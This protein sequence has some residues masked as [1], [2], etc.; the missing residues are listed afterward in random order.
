MSAVGS[1]VGSDVGAD[2]VTAVGADVGD[3]LGPAVG[4]CVGTDVGDA[5]GPDVGDAVGTALGRC[6]G[7]AVGADVGAAV[8]RD[9]GD[10][11]GP[12]ARHVAPS[13]LSVATLALTRVIPD[14]CPGSP[15][16]LVPLSARL[17]RK[18]T[19]ARPETSPESSRGWLE[20]G[21]SGGARPARMHP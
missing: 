13:P 17:R 18:T 2:V 3:A 8:G 16:P 15:A 14:G 4:A 1:P 5:V 9:V 11:V 19:Q 7:T 6:V 21:E 10:G 12:G 20:P